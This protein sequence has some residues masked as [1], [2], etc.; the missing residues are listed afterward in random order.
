MSYVYVSSNIPMVISLMTTTILTMVS[1]SAMSLL[2]LGCAFTLMD[3]VHP[4]SH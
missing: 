4:L 2:A 3:L 1:L